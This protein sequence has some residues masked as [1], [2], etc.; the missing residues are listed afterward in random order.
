MPQSAMLPDTPAKQG[1]IIEIQCNTDNEYDGCIFTHIKPFD[2]GQ[3]YGQSGIQDF[4]CS[5]GHD[6]QSSTTCDDDN[7]IS[8]IKSAT[9]CGIRISNPLPDDTGIWKVVT[10]ELK[11]GGQ[12][13]SNNKDVNVYVFN[14][15]KAFLQTKRNEEPIPSMYEVNYN[16]D[17]WRDRWMDGTGSYETHELMCVSKYGRPAPE[18][19]WSIN[20][21]ELDNGNI[22]KIMDGK[23]DTYDVNG[24]VYDWESELRF[25]VDGEF[26][27]YLYNEHGI[28]TNPESGEFS[29]DLECNANQGTNG[30][31]YS[32]RVYTRV[33]VKRIYDSDR[34]T[35]SEIGYVVGGVLGGLA[36][37][38]II[39]VL[40]V[41]FLKS[42]ERGCFANDDYQYRDPQD[43]NRPPSHAQR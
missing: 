41:I 22:F 35:N 7:R 29:F 2:Y 23:G 21:E 8:M 27:D 39:A 16:Y 1:Q 6:G 12:L 17:D 26:L 25:T 24:L 19:V 30:E 28:D 9:M 13:Q 3:S 38:I 36:V 33:T 20:R 15:T 18:I 10:S 43:K 42:T 34:L 40:L 31:Y 11:Q 4:S 37:I 14:Q 32:E 5:I